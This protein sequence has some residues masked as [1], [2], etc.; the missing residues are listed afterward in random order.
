MRGGGGVGARSG[1]AKSALRLSPYADR[2]PTTTRWRTQN[3]GT[4]VSNTYRVSSAVLTVESE[5]IF[6]THWLSLKAMAPAPKSPSCVSAEGLVSA[7]VPS[8]GVLHSGQISIASARESAEASSAVAWIRGR[9]ARREVR[10]ARA[11]VLQLITLS[12]Y[13]P[14]NVKDEQVLRQF[15]QHLD[16]RTMP[17]DGLFEH[18]WR[19]YSN[20]AYRGMFLSDTSGQTNK[21]AT[22]AK[23]LEDIDRRNTELAREAAEEGGMTDDRASALRPRRDNLEPEVLA[24]TLRG[25]LDFS[26]LGDCEDE[27]GLWRFRPTRKKARAPA[28][29]PTASRRP[30]LEAL[31]HDY[32]AIVLQQEAEEPEDMQPYHSSVDDDARIE[33][34]P[35][36]WPARM[37]RI[38]FREGEPMQKVRKLEEMRGA[39]FPYRRSCRPW[40]SPSSAGSHDGGGALRTMIYAVSWVLWLFGWEF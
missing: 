21:T 1:S 35:D 39:D 15:W 19:A 6:G 9:R 40:A 22:D 2:R 11:S 38:A 4:S 33:F 7:N 5:S 31:A 25:R 12:S 30:S 23:L 14:E 8:S 16:E 27:P 26:L 28:P 32:R 29:Y 18:G 13:L 34:A 24:E 10:L 36:G 37:T 20:Q 3:C 17:P